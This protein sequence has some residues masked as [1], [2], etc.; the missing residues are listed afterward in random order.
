MAKVRADQ[1]L[2][3][4][5]LAESRTKAQALIMAGSVFT[6]ERRIDKPGQM[7]AGDLPLEV[8]G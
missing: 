2:V 8:R 6:G 3:E 5:G 4:C 1:L 7:V